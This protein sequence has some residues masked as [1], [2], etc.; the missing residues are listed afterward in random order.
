MVT[1]SDVM[2]TRER[3]I[4]SG[5][6]EQRVNAKADG[7]WPMDAGGKF[8]IG[9]WKPEIPLRRGPAI[10]PMEAPRKR[11]RTCRAQGSELAPELNAEPSEL[12]REPGLR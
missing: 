5:S 3:I 2:Y 8:R 6:T 7:R 10:A 12:E 4:G 11:L 1:G 9:G